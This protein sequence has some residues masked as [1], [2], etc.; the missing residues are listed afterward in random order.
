MT[1]ELTLDSYLGIDISADK[2]AAALFFVRG[3]EGFSCTYEQLLQFVRNNGVVYGI[4]DEILLAIMH[5]PSA[6]AGRQTVFA[7]GTPPQNG[8]DG[9]ITLAF[10]SAEAVPRLME[11]EDGKVDFREVS[12][13]VNVV[14]GQ[15]IAQKSRPTDATQGRA[16]T[17]EVLFGKNGKPARFKVGKN[18]VVN[19]EETAMYAAIDGLVSMTDRDRINVFPV[20]E[21]NGD[22]DYNIGNINFVGNVVIRGNVL[23]GFQVKAAGDIRVIGGVEGA[24]LEAEGSIEITGGI[25]AGNKGY[26]KAGKNLRCSFIQD[27]QAFAAE[28]ILVSLSIMHSNLRAGRNIICGGAKGLLVGGV[29]Q[30]GELVQARTIGNSMSTATTIEVGVHPEQRSRLTDLRKQARA[31]AESLDKAEKALAILDQMAAAGQLTPDR[32]AMRIKLAATK[33]QSGEQLIIVKEEILAIEKVLDDT[34]K[35]RVE[36]GGTLYGGTKIVIG[37]YTR[38]IKEPY[39]RTAFHYHD[40]EIVQASL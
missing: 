21:V 38:F 18:V 17:G 24:E 7:T 1:Q 9:Q 22:V 29:V 37:R 33:R 16:V 31:N 34:G 5:N 12:R 20:Y 36:V 39:R 26:V 28:D 14:R 8:E 30:A 27:G 19:Q 23:T 2:L 25:V 10:K 11:Q 6:Y 35:A 40:G 13:I 32:M 4:Q 3:V 15:L